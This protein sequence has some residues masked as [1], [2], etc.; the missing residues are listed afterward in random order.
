MDYQEAIRKLVMDP[1]MESVRELIIGVAGTITRKN[2]EMLLS[3]QSI[4][5]GIRKSLKN[6]RDAMRIHLIPTIDDDKDFYEKIVR[7]AYL[8]L[9]RMGG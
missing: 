9:I 4:P 3:K 7:P 1:K 6:I 2:I 8:E 5:N